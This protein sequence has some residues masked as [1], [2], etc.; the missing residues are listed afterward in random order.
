MNLRRNNEKKKKVSLS[1][2]HTVTHTHTKSADRHQVILEWWTSTGT[3]Q[4]SRPGGVIKCEPQSYTSAIM[5]G[6]YGSVSDLAF[7]DDLLTFI[8]H[9]LLETIY[10][11][12]LPTIIVI[13]V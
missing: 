9:P 4:L 3:S 1:L 10:Y 2:L 11:S 13:L 6:Q 5:I 7:R 8:F 12:I